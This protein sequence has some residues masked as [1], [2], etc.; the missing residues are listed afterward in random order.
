MLA[1][2]R[3]SLAVIYQSRPE[4]NRPMAARTR[5]FLNDKVPVISGKSKYNFSLFIH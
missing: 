5:P 4:I 2:I 3:S 1:E